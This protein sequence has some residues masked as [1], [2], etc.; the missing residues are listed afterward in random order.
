MSTPM[1][2]EEKLC[3]N[4]DFEKIDQAY[5][6]SL[7]GCLMYLTTIYFECQSILSRFM[8]NS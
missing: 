8:H 4:D 5:F 1:N 2:S 7:V 3:K 6:K